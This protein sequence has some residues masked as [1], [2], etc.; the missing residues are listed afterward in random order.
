MKTRFHTLILG[1][2]LLGALLPGAGCSGGKPEGKK[3]VILAFDGMDPRIVRELFAEGKLPH[4]KKLSLTGG[5]RDLWSSIPP[6][7]PVA[8]SNFITGKNPGGHGIFDFI[9]RSPEDYQP[10]LSVSRAVPPDKSKIVSLG[11]YRIPLAGGKV[12]LLRRGKAF[13]E[14]LEEASIPAVVFRIPS[15]FPPAGKNTQSVSGMGTPDLLGTYGT[16]QYFPTDPADIP[17]DYGG[18]IMKLVYPEDDLIR[19]S[20]EGPPNSFLEGNPV[21]EIPFTVRVD[22]ENPVARIDLPDRS[23]ILNQG[24]WSEWLTVEFQALPLPFWGKITGICRFYLKEAGEDF[25]LYV[26][27]LNVDPVSPDLPIDLPAGFAREVAGEAGLFYTQGMPEDTKALD[28]GTLTMDEFAVQA[29]MVLEESNLIFDKLFAKY[30]AGLFFYYYSSTDLGSHMFWSLRDPQSPIYDQA[31]SERLGDRIAMIYEE[32]DKVVGKVMERFGS[33]AA[34]IVMSD[35]GFGPLY[36][37]FHLNTWLKQNGYLTARADGSIDYSRTRAY[38]L[39]LNGLYIN[40]R[41]RESRGAV[42][43]AQVEDLIRELKEKLEAFTDP[44]N[45]K[46]VIRRVHRAA[47]VYSGEFAEEAPDLLVG[48]DWGYRTAY[49][50]ALGQVTDE[51]VTTN[52][53]KWSADHCGATEIVPGVLFSNL[54]LLRENPRLY[55]ITPAILEYFGLPVPEDMNGT[56]VFRPGGGGMRSLPYI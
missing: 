3:M 13:W 1:A 53:E 45:G 12:L 43:E 27:P 52:M 8:W 14:Y 15:N 22:P 29:G 31:T 38:A 48:Y 16:Y 47:E 6:Q 55:D 42:A 20:L 4:L 28:N 37:N 10:F 51:L 39:G 34:L 41:G 40:R 33:E 5:F 19:C 17:D 32:M 36:R 26:T 7:S 24:E 23:V 49:Q 21:M 11:K 18:A 54:P 35:H 25:K 2:A 56:S 50:S 30:R 44:E 46:S 9:H